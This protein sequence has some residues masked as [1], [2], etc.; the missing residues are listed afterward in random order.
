MI[1]RILTLTALAA[2]AFG[3]PAQDAKQRVAARLSAVEALLA[4]GAVR[5][6]ATGT[7]E[8]ARELDPQQAETVAQ[9]NADRATIF[10]EIA[11]VSGMP[12][13]GVAQMYSRRAQKRAPVTNPAANVRPPAPASCGLVAASSADVARLLQFMKQGMTYASSRNFSAALNEWRQ[14]LKADPNFLGLRQNIGGALMALRQFDEAESSLRDELRLA[15]C[16]QALDDASLALFAQVQEVAEKEP[17]LRP[18]AQAKVLRLAIPKVVANAN[19]N[20]ACVYSNKQD[21]ARGIEALRAAVASGF[22]D[23]KAATTDADLAFL[24]AAPE[25]QDILGGIK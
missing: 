25:F 14:G 13:E 5:E 7:L 24:R 11:R 21:K 2:L 19:Y 8:A 22:N 6:G 18:A 12:Q 15:G 3:Q 20:L 17:S 1:H 4:S 9:E 23:R 16:L 10:A